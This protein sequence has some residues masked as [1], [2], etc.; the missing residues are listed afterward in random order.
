MRKLLKI[1]AS[2]AVLG[3]ILGIFYREFTKLNGFTGITTL[4]FLHVHTLVLGMFM[5]L[6]LVLME[7]QFQ[8]S[9]AKS[10]KPF[11][12]IYNLGLIMTIIMMMVRGIPQVLDTNLSTGMN[13]AISGMS[14]VGHILLAVGLFFLFKAL[15]QKIKD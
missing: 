15:F 11:L 9:E 8:L 13:A 5:F 7:I 1:A 2:Y 6:I 12:I 3:L 14:G 10:F 4:G